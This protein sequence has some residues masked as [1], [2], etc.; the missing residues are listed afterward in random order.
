VENYDDTQECVES[1]IEALTSCY[2]LETIL[3]LTQKDIYE[4]VEDRSTGN[5]NINDAIQ[6]VNEWLQT[7][8]DTNK[9]VV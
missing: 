2:L 1:V 5:T 6:S 8:K 4:A 7:F 9:E 3:T